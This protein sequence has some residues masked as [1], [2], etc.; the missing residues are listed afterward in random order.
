MKRIVLSA[1]L[2]T[3]AFLSAGAAQAQFYN[4]YQQQY[5][6]WN[7]SFPGLRDMNPYGSGYKSYRRQYRHLLN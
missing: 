4:P 7:N 2:A 5:R 3:Q 6:Q 1:L